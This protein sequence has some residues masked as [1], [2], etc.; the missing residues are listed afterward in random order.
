MR[1]L[2]FF[3]EFK[4]LGNSND[5]I[6]LSLL[7][8]QYNS[9]KIFEFPQNIT[10]TLKISSSKYTLEVNSV[11]YGVRTPIF[12]YYITSINVHMDKDSFSF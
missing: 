7:S 9:P 12:I 5:L 8:K 4:I 3:K 6:K 2:K 11:E 1:Y 10:F